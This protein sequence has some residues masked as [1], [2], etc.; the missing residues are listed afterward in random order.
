MSSFVRACLTLVP[1]FVR[2][3]DSVVQ[4][5]PSFV[6]RRMLLAVV[7]VAVLGVVVAILVIFLLLSLLFLSA[8]CVASHPPLVISVVATCWFRREYRRS[9]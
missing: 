6:F 2:I 3:L 1:A 9:F 7:D 8:W 5:A 4:K